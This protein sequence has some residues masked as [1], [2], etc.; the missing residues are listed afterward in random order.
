MTEKQSIQI[1]RLTQ[2]NYLDTYEKKLIS[3]EQ[4]EQ[5]FAYSLAQQQLQSLLNCGLISLVEFNKIMQI[6]RDTFSPFLVEIMP[7][8]R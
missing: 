5:D 4:L 2:S 3:Q 1:T 8:I 7:E 6:N